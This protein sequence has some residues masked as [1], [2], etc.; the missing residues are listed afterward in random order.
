[1]SN[2]A[3]FLDRDGVLN[4]AVD[5]GGTPHP[6][7]SLDDLQVLPGVADA[8]AELTASGFVLLVVTNQPDIAR[9]TADPAVVDAMNNRLMHELHL[10]GVLMCPHDD[11]D[12]CRCRKPQPGLLI[13]AATRW[14]IDLSASYMV[15]DRWRDIEAG[16]RAGCATVLVDRSYSEQRARDFDV[17]VRDLSEAAEWILAHDLRISRKKVTP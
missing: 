11:V 9:G 5:V 8:C 13:D 17:A 6:P 7:S 4:A 16:R 14:D 15:G 12:E 1:V 2:R 3:V 10:D